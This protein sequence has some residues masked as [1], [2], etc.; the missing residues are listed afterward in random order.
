MHT[1]TKAMLNRVEQEP[2][3]ARI[4]FLFDFGPSVV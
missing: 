3:D 4:F 2:A 1:V